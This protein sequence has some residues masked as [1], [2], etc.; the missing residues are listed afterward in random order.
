MKRLR[1][2][3]G[4]CVAASAL[5]CADAV[6]PATTL[7]DGRTVAELL[8]PRHP[9]VVLF[10][11]P[12]DCFSCG[13]PLNEWRE[14]ASAGR[15]AMVVVLNREPE[16]GERRALRIQRV[17][18]SGVYARPWY[19]RVPVTPQELLFDATGTL[20]ERSDASGGAWTSR[21]LSAAIAMT[22]PADTTRA[23]VT[24]P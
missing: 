8:S 4:V 21:A 12:T 1:Q 14:L 20:V 13:L 23:P 11:S 6:G 24:V 9:T 17:P 19:R 22:A 16:E 10:Y 5:A 2:L 7:V 15:I 3:A 18:I